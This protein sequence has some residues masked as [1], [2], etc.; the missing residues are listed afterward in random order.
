M[1]AK[2]IVIVLFGALFLGAAGH[3]APASHR[4]WNVIDCGQATAVQPE[5]G[6]AFRGVVANEDYGLSARIPSGLTGWGGVAKDAP[7]HG[8]TIFLDSQK[9]ACIDFQIHIRVD[10]DDAP[11]RSLH[12]TSMRLGKARAWQSI[13]EGRVADESVT[14]IRTSFSFKQPNQVDD[15]EVLLIVPTSRLPEAKRTYDAFIRSLKFSR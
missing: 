1:M 13:R 15:G 12:A 5:V 3:A 4:G 10:D 14:N 9:K 8:F 6:N 7:F 11:K 2:V